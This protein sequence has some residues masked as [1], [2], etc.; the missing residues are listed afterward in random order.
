LQLRQHG[1]G[2]FTER[3]EFPLLYAEAAGMIGLSEPRA[4]AS[5]ASV[6]STER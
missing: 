1:W 4:T 5:R 6:S 3:F 2:G